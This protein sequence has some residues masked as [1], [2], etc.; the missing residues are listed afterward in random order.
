MYLVQ[1]HGWT[2]FCSSIVLP[3]SNYIAR[4]KRMVTKCSFCFPELYFSTNIT[5][6]E[7]LLPVFDV[8]YFW[9]IAETLFLIYKKIVQGENMFNLHVYLLLFSLKFAGFPNN[10]RVSTM[11]PLRT[12]SPHEQRTNVIYNI[13]CSDFSW[14]Y[15]G[16][17][18]RSFQT[19]K[20]EHI[21]NVKNCKKG[22]NISKHAWG[23]DHII[24]L[25]SGKVIDSGYYQ[26]RKTLKSWHTAL[27]PNSD[28]NSKPLPKQYAML[29]NKI[30][31]R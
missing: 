25:E 11:L 23:Y 10:L 3:M 2:S 18:G 15:V 8:E 29:V 22:S 14:L 26:T 4:W 30:C 13:P 1:S 17:T 20:K 24:D 9:L 6:K 27:I 16:E 19:R 28:D 21:W 7:I 5:N 31:N 12:N